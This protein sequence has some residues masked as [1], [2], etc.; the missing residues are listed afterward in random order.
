VKPAQERSNSGYIY[1]D[2]PLREA[3]EMGAQLPILYDFIYPFF[4]K[5]GAYHIGKGKKTTF[6]IPNAE[7]VFKN[8]LNLALNQG[9]INCNWPVLA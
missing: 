7:K 9:I 8:Y 3:R 6:S 2:A 5:C 4:E 1:T